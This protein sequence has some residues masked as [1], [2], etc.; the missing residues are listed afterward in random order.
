MGRAIAGEVLK[1]RTTRTS[2]VLALIALGLI[3]LITG[4]AAATTEWNEP[5]AA[6]RGA[7]GVDTPGVDMLAIAG[8]SQLFAMV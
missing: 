4:L 6:G 8:V 1:M 7:P 3:A 2:L 5:L